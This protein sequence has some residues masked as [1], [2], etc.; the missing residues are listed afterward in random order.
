L[1]HYQHKQITNWVG[2]LISQ[3]LLRM[4]AEEY[5][6]LKITDAGR[7]ALKSDARL[8]LTGFAARPVKSGG[9]F[10]SAQGE[11]ETSQNTRQAVNELAV[12]PALH[13]R[14]RQWRNQKAKALDL[15]A[16][17]VLHNSALE[18]IARLQ[19]RTLGELQ[20]VRGIGSR[21]IEQ[22]GQEIIELM[23]GYALL[24]PSDGT[25]HG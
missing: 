20:A 23:Q 10:A 9:T 24:A 12:D 17:C 4:T 22:F 15:P 14:L 3:H 11:A 19:P 6:R 13:E 5:P 25:T 8:A 18:V 21:K 2:E 1:S 16:Y 7:Q